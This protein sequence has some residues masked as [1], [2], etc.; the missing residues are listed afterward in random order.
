MRGKPSPWGIKLYLLCGAGGMVYDL[1]LNQGS[2]T[3]LDQENKADFGLGGS[4]VLKLCEQIKKNRHILYFDNFFTSYNLLNALQDQKIYAAGTARVNRFG[5]PPLITDKNFKKM[6]RGT[7]FEVSGS[8]EYGGRTNQIG[9]IKWFDNKGVVIAS[10]FLTSGITDEVNRWDK[11][12]K[13]YIT[14][15]RPEIIKLYNKSMGGVDL[16]DQL[17][18]YFRIFIRSR[19]WTLRMVTHS[20][21]MALTNSW[22]E[23]RNDAIQCNIKEKMDLLLF[24][25]QVAKTLVILG[26]AQTYTPE[27]K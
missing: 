9:M 21:D 20:F 24:K 10:N 14:L 26:K 12:E 2:N 22:M 3:E 27:R 19:K 13:K 8:T 1:L 15:E 25:Q 4:V 18:S 5:N 11:K 23:Y 6:D 17:V 7:S 16:H